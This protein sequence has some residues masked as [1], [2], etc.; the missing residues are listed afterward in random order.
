MK[1]DLKHMSKIFYYVKKP[2]TNKFVQY[3]SIPVNTYASRT[4][5]GTLKSGDNIHQIR[6]S[7]YFGT[8]D[9]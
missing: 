3:H 6:N 9:W 8:W 5:T 4:H 1:C 2:G 7:D